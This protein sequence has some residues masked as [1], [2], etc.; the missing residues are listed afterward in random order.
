VMSLIMVAFIA[1]V[2]LMSRRITTRSRHSG[3]GGKATTR[4]ARRAMGRWKWP[5]RAAIILYAML[6]TLFPA[7]ALLIVALNGYWTSNIQWS[8]FSFDAFS[9]GILDNP[10]TVEAIENSFSLA[11]VVATLGV[12]IA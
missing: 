8:N 6:G 12:F 4:P 11:L 3:V 2:W 1:V 5:I 10:L 9:G 7:I